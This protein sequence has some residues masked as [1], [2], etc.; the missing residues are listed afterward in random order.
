[1]CNVNLQCLA[2]MKESQVERVFIMF[3]DFEVKVHLIL[4][5]ETRGQKWLPKDVRQVNWCVKM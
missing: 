1:V 4:E 5:I 3:V 2:A